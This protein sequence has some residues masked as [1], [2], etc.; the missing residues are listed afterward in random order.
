[1]SDVDTDVLIIG[2]GMA[3]LVTALNASERRVCVLAPAAFEGAETASDLAQGGIAAALGEEDSPALHLTD[4]LRAGSHH[5][6]SAA[7]W[8][9]CREA[10]AA[11][12]YLAALGVPFSQ[13]A[14]EWSLHKEA[15]HSRARVLHVG[16]DATGAAIMN[17]LRERV[18]AAPHIEVLSDAR[19]IA[20]LRDPI[21]VCGVAAVTAKAQPLVVRAR[22]VV[23]ATG[24][25]GGL[26]SRSTNPPEACGD[27]PAMAL[28]AGARCDDLEFVQFHPTALDV[29]AAPL[30]LMTEALRGAGA[31]LIDD[32]G[33]RFVS[34]VHPLGE[35]AP[36]DVVARA[37]F[38]AQARGRRV[39]LDATRLPGMK[40]SDAFRS[41]YRICRA[42]GIDADRAP[43]PVTPATHYHMGGIA[44]D[45][46]G[47]TTLPRLWAV[48]E[49]ACTGLH[50]ANRLAS[51]SLLE[52]VVLGR[53]LG[54][55][56]NI[57]LP[58]AQ[59]R[60]VQPVGIG[61][62]TT[63]DWA[64]PRELRE[65]MWRRMGLVRNARGIAEG[66]SLVTRLREQTPLTATLRRSRLLL[67]EQMMLA[68]A[69]RL[70]SCGAHYRS[71]SSDAADLVPH[72]SASREYQS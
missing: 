13:E 10:P 6:L 54:Q 61:W 41:V 33:D 55:A 64:A 69:R 39:W 45:L 37:I 51:N 53:R 24:G 67:A 47:R 42:Y 46:D 29:D 30:P 19:A 43:I 49:A 52:A 18:V 58:E 60:E 36:R 38:D 63:A 4:T 28:S 23:I 34:K 14:G 65:I 22:D 2:A 71:D 70:T 50:G 17:I 15:A 27:G 32:L 48:G 66:L 20:L 57:E 26:Y 8:Y 5:N 40:V 59:H 25:I 3:G 12:H 62:D 21:G 11:V 72:S 35:L 16:G 44:V 9:V 56:L 1:M 7:A 31:Q 68:A